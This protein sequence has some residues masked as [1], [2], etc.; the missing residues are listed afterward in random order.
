[1]KITLIHIDKLKLDKNCILIS[2]MCNWCAN[3]LT[4]KGQPQDVEDF[5]N[6]EIIVPNN[7]SGT[8]DEE[9]VKDGHICFKETVDD[10]PKN[11]LDCT[12]IE[13]VFDEGDRFRITFDTRWQPQIDWLKR[14]A[15]KYPNLKFILAY[16]ESGI[17]FY[18]KAV[19]H[20]RKFRDERYDIEEGEDVIYYIVDDD[21]NII[22]EATEDEVQTEDLAEGESLEQRPAGQLKKY[23]EKY[24][25]PH[26]GG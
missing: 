14:L 8:S 17:G 1:M 12:D 19:A 11:S 25:I 15:K 9:S 6:N 2:K 20:G 24:G 7:R 21:E 5:K 26:L 4:V 23:F 3:A 22:R 16:C 18:G 10:D 13:N